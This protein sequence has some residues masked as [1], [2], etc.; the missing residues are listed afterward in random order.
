MKFETA[1]RGHHY[2]DDQT[3]GAAEL[4]PVE[5]VCCGTESFCPVPSGFYQTNHCFEDRHVVVDDADEGN[6]GVLT[7][8]AQARGFFDSAFYKPLAPG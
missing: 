6:F 4:R 5:K 3:G 8:L 2:I 7:V 1:D